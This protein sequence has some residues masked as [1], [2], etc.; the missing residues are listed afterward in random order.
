MDNCERIIKLAESIARMAKLNKTLE[1]QR[2]N[3]LNKLPVHIITNAEYF[4]G[5]Y[6]YPDTNLTGLCIQHTTRNICNN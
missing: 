2:K 4:E 5:G 1:P 3:Q 6:N